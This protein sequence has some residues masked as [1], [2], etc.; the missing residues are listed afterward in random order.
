MAHQLH[1][2]AAL[3]GQQVVLGEAFGDVGSVAAEDPG[4]GL[5]HHL[6]VGRRLA[7]LAQAVE[8][9]G[10]GDP[11]RRPGQRNLRRLGRGIAVDEVERPGLGVGQQ[12]VPVH[13][14]AVVGAQVQ[15]IPGLGRRPGHRGRAHGL[16]DLDHGG[17]ETAW[18]QGT[19][20]PAHEHFLAPAPGRNDADA[21]LHQADVE[22]GMGLDGVAVQE[23]L[24]PAAERHPGRRAD[25]R[26]GGVLEGLVRVLPLDQHV[27]DHRPGGEVGGEQ[28]QP[29]VGAGREVA[30]LVVDH[31]GLVAVGDDADGLADHRQGAQVERVHLGVELQAHH[32]VADVPQ[33]GRGV[34]RHGLAAQFH[35]GQQKH[36]G[37][38]PHVGVPAVERQV[39]GAALVGAVE[40]AG[41]H[42]FQ[43]IG[44]RQAVGFQLFG[45]PRGA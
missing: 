26:E 38:A 24:A 44:H 14:D 31:Q 28:H 32:A 30:A 19:G 45:E 21:G 5:G 16:E 36:A 3:E 4:Q 35:V 34:P 43:Q 9:H 10:Q 13:G 7:Q 20:G 1:E 27:L 8:D 37:G 23:N 29:Q 42:R 41:A 15:E 6:V 12:A 39:L 11:R 40:G 22:L 17:H 2:G 18:A 25:H 33:A